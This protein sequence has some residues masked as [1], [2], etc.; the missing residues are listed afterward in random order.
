MLRLCIL[1]LTIAN[2]CAVALDRADDTTQPKEQQ[3]NSPTSKRQKNRKKRRRRN[4]VLWGIGAATVASGVYGAHRY[5]QKNKSDL[6]PQPATIPT[7]PLPEPSPQQIEETMPSF[8]AADYGNKTAHLQR[9]NALC[10]KQWKGITKR[11]GYQVAVP[12]FT[13]LSSTAV[14]Q[15]LQTHLHFDFDA[16][17]QAMASSATAVIEG[18]P[19]LA[20]KLATSWEM[21]TAAPQEEASWQ[22]LFGDD[23]A[24]LEK[25]FSRHADANERFMIRSSGKEDTA[26]FANAGGN[27]SI[28]NVP[29]TY[30]DILQALQRV[31]LSYI[32]LKSLEQRRAAG[33]DITCLPFVPVLIQR[34]I[35]E[36]NDD[37]TPPSC[38]VMYTEEQEGSTFHT[39]GKS[40]GIIMIQSAFG[41]NELVV[42]GLGPVD[43]F[44]VD[45]DNGVHSRIRTKPLRLTPKNAGVLAKTENSPNLKSSSSLDTPAII[46]LTMIA[47]DLEQEYE[48]PQDVEFVVAKEDN[49]PTLYLV[50][51]RPIPGKNSPTP[52]YLDLAAVSTLPAIHGQ[53]YGY[54]GGF[55]R[56]AHARNDII[57][58]PNLLAA[59]TAYL[60]YSKEQQESVKCI[61][62]HEEVVSTSHEAN[63]MRFEQK[64]VICMREKYSQAI[65]FVHTTNWNTHQLVID[66]QQSCLIRLPAEAELPIIAGWQSYPLPSHLSVK[67]ISI[68][69]NAPGIQQVL[70]AHTEQFTTAPKLTEAADNPE[71]SM[72]KLRRLCHSIKT[73]IGRE[74]YGAIADL[75][76]TLNRIKLPL[77]NPDYETRL[78]S[79]LLAIGKTLNT[80]YKSSA[81][82]STTPDYTAKR[83]LPAFVL[84]TLMFQ[85]KN[86]N[87]CLFAD[88]IR[89]LVGMNKREYKA[90]EGAE[91]VTEVQRLLMTGRS[92]ALKAEVTKHWERFVRSNF[93][94]ESL[95]AAAQ[96]EFLRNL[97]LLQ[98]LDMFQLWLN[99][100]FQDDQTIEKLNTDIA[101]ASNFLEQLKIK[102][103][104]LTAFNINACADPKTFLA[105]WEFFNKEFVD[106][107]IGDDFMGHFSA[108]LSNKL[109]PAAPAESAASGAGQAPEISLGQEVTI[110]PR[111]E[112]IAILQFMNKFV[113]T[114]DATIKAITSS[115]E[116]KGE[117]CSRDDYPALAQSDETVQ[118][119]IE[120]EKDKIFAFYCTLLKHMEVLQKW[121]AVLEQHGLGLP[122]YGSRFRI[123][124]IV[125][126]PILTVEKALT[127]WLPTLINTACKNTIDNQLA[128]GDFEV[129]A[130]VI[131][132]ETDVTIGT[133]DGVFVK[134]KFTPHTF[135]AIFTYLHQSTLAV[136]QAITL[137]AQAAALLPDPC[138]F[139]LKAL[140][141]TFNKEKNDFLYR[142]VSSFNPKLTTISIQRDITLVLNIPLQLHSARLKFIYSQQK[143]CLHIMF[144]CFGNNL[145]APDFNIGRFDV[146]RYYSESDLNKGKPNNFAIATPTSFSASWKI[147]LPEGLSTIPQIAQTI[148]G[149]IGIVNGD[150]PL[151]R[152]GI[153]RQVPFNKTYVCLLKAAITYAKEKKAAWD[154]LSNFFIASDKR[155]E[156]DQETQYLISLNLILVLVNQWNALGILN[157]KLD[158]HLQET[159]ILSSLLPENEISF[160]RLLQKFPQL[161]QENFG[162]LS[163]ECCLALSKKYKQIMALRPGTLV[164][165]AEV[166]PIKDTMTAIMTAH[167]LATDIAA[168]A[169]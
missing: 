66:P 31:V 56:V 45:S 93:S 49:T 19:L 16:Q 92:Q 6:P 54:A 126:G 85:E 140:L 150:R 106:W 9:L 111:V 32:S 97:S 121:Y 96:Q 86:D 26:T 74:F 151:N 14:K 137:K 165:T 98:A 147:K 134:T 71:F 7:P 159:A 133:M 50:Q 38:G 13:G 127:E 110:E 62:V 128:A 18:S 146:C 63:T 41:H 29:A 84:E 60:G 53:A 164:G 169:P 132:S 70:A 12:A 155:K 109:A 65:E 73:K 61:M 34:M 107:I 36:R 118:K 102:T 89:Q 3:G 168:N 4:A 144:D 91:P 23:G 17:W 124:S 115:H 21:F 101:A 2:S 95:H 120:E 76:Q 40:S 20:A 46:A 104:G 33:D 25:F 51:T 69:P 77:K 72:Q 160:S 64:P 8:N 75:W 122:D 153:H 37:V 90:A 80:L 22:S 145:K 67:Q 47:R 161:F 24:E 81:I 116:F 79:L 148:L 11:T 44:L 48:I 123:G 141:S 1:F 119:Q 58:A 162:E 99:I 59:L 78:T 139:A 117:R 156:C 112:L 15:F 163:P 152:G 5:Y 55:I 142:K 52:S 82:S 157:K 105:A 114:F 28:A 131:G 27:E 125:R 113:S 100:N 129:N 94:D 136:I 88:S 30:R 87:E 138:A 83:L 130:A 166:E 143:N 42:N 158:A 149:Y 39:T 43:T 167:G 68:Q 108:L 135:E 57:Y 10:K 103:E 35:G 154:D